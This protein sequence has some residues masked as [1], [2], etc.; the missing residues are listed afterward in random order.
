M[1]TQP[2]INGEVNAVGSTN[3]RL[4]VISG[5][6]EGAVT[7]DRFAKKL[8]GLSWRL[9]GTVKRSGYFKTPH[10]FLEN[11]SYHENNFSGDLHYDHRQWGAEVF[12]SQFDTKIGLFTGAQ[13][14]SLADLYAAISRSEPLSQPGFSYALNR[15]YQD[16]KHGLLKFRAYIRTNR[17]GTI[18]AT[19]A[20][21]QNTRQE[22]DYVSFSVALNPEL[23]LQLVTQT[24]DLV[25]EHSSI[26][27]KRSK[28]AGIWSGS[29]GFNGITQGNVRKFLFLIPNFRNYGA[30]LFAIERYAVDRWTLEAGLRYDYRWLRAYF[31]NDATKE[32]YF[33]THHWANANG[34][35]GIAYQ[36]RPN[37]TLTANFSTAWRAPNVADLYSDGLHQ[38]AVAYERGNPN[39]NPEQAYNGNIVLAYAGKRLSGEVGLYNNLI[40]NYIYLK[41]DS[42]PIIRQR[43]AFPAYS[44]AQVKA[45]FRGIDATLTYKFTDQLSLTTKN[46]LLFAYNH[47]D[48]DYLVFVPPNRSDNSLRYDWGAVGPVVEP[49]C[50][51]EWAVCSAPESGTRRNE[52][53]GKRE[54]SVPG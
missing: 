38:S 3:G 33:T 32:T 48:Q 16:V 6:V 31:L 47:T 45:S 41:P 34:S 39:L 18:T 50:F 20:R 26:K 7:T 29:A 24:A 49:V 54:C 25:W 23:Y 53:A 40:N 2:G 19:V 42:V 35:L 36:L 43:G 21:Q 22:Y 15:P 51:G 9:Q 44:Y 4:G 8:T 37:L 12:Y 10:Y 28:G 1:P 30:G 11:T 46:S 17:G 5:M 52:Y 14:G 27:N 13:V